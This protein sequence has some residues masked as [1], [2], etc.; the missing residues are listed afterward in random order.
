MKKVGVVI[1]ALAAPVCLLVISVAAFAGYRATIGKGAALTP[2]ETGA[3]NCAIAEIAAMAKTDP[4]KANRVILARVADCLAMMMKQKP[5]GICRETNAK[6]GKG[7]ALPDKSCKW[8]GD[9]INISDD[10]L[11]KT[12]PEL[13]FLVEVL[14]HEGIH[15]IQWDDGS[16]YAGT[17]EK[18]EWVAWSWGK[19]ILERRLKE[20]KKLTQKQKDAIKK[21]LEDVV[22]PNRD[23]YCKAAATQREKRKNN[24][25]AGRRKRSR[26]DVT[27]EYRS[28]T[29]ND[30]NLSIVDLNNYQVARILNTGFATNTD[31]YVFA[32]QLGPDVLYVAGTDP[33]TLNGG[34]VVFTDLDM[35]GLLDQASLAILAGPPL[36]LPLAMD[37]DELAGI[38]YLLEHDPLD[39]AQI[40]AFN[41]TNADGLPDQLQPQ[42][43]AH[44]FAFPPLVDVWTLQWEGPG[45]VLG[46]Q[47]Q[48]GMTIEND[49][50]LY[51]N[52]VDGNFDGQADALVT[53][54]L[55][56]VLQPL[57]PAFLDDLQDQDVVVRLLA[58]LGASLEVWLT[59]VTGT[60]LLTQV[61]SGPATAL[62]R[63][64]LINLSQ[65]L[66]QGQYVRAFDVANGVSD[67]EPKQVIAPRPEVIGIDLWEAVPGDLV[68][69]T[70]RNFSPTATVECNGVPASVTFANSNV[71]TFQAPAVSQVPPSA[72]VV[73]VTTGQ[74]TS[75]IVGLMLHGDCNGNSIAD[76]DDIVNGTS[77]DVDGNGVPDECE[78][79]T[80]APEN[81]CTAGTS[82]SGCNAVMYGL[83]VASASAG[84][85]FELAAVNVE[86][87]K[88]GLFFFGSN[89][90][91]ASSWGSGTSFQ[92]V[93][94]PVSRAGLLPGVGTSGACDGVFS[95][96]MNALW[97]PS[98]PKPA[99]NPGAGATVQAQ[100]WYRDPFN[101]SNQ[102]TSLSDALEFVVCP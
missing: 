12:E 99:K 6:A 82:A 14:L 34:V 4:S 42:P 86:G 47:R 18:E 94:P 76:I 44:E 58:N 11:K 80:S 16:I 3:V 45:H 55:N 90:R 98:C 53:D 78:P 36:A 93:V 31:M 63:I 52:F 61:G 79:C 19:Y 27:L 32:S 101:T 13:S 65:P 73:E 97:C 22:C 23:S 89:G 102:T 84:A 62:D 5:A 59:D 67:A 54:T 1:R 30:G 87:G 96:D 40:L 71:I 56:D 17:E 25:K 41:D 51:H 10:C 69:L 39:Q 100:C 72:S 43:F 38:L 64:N 7:M 57:P 88:D 95:Q 74:G 21:E 15:A 46:S 2:A 92:C 20:N 8:S 48:F 85:G 9:K 24:A 81:Y 60:V 29:P 70:G 50:I 66:L 83:G 28:N 77:L 33:A 37:A 49:K 91:Q 35:D 68:T 75:G 26:A